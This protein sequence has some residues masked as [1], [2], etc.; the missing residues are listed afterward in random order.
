VF[1][2]LSSRANPVANLTYARHR[3][4]I[5]QV[6]QPFF[7][8]VLLSSWAHPVA[9]HMYARHRC[10][11]PCGPHIPIRLR[12]AL[13]AA[14]DMLI[15]C[16]ARTQPMPVFWFWCRY[17]VCC[18]RDGCL[19]HMLHE[20]VGIRTFG[21][22]KSTPHKVSSMSIVCICYHRIRRHTDCY[23]CLQPECTCRY[24]VCSCCDERR[25]RSCATSAEDVVRDWAFIG[26]PIPESLAIQTPKPQPVLHELV[27]VRTFWSTNFTC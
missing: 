26:Q 11:I 14:F 16:I 7:V 12:F 15:A 20:L 6:R 22:P 18:C 5:G 21:F 13:H 2:L 24:K 27:G 1:V 17:D 8:L 4:W 10:R 3:G 9:N 23:L 25:F 19:R